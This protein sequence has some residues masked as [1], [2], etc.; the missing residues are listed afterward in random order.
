MKSKPTPETSPA[1]G[2]VNSGTEIHFDLKDVLSAKE[3]D[4]F[5]A[6][7]SEAKA[8]NLTEHFLDLTLRVKP[9]NAA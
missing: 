7:A 8:P 6:A 9:G 2:P 5:K 1:S 4:D 3:L